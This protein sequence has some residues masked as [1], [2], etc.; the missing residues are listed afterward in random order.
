MG[1]RAD[2]Q[3]NERAKTENMEMEMIGLEKNGGQLS[4]GKESMA[5]AARGGSGGVLVT[6]N[7]FSTSAASG[8]M[9]R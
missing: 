7:S 5:P 2:G 1:K 3:K 4:E 8:V 9:S 6:A